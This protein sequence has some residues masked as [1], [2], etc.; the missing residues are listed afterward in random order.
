M[1]HKIQFTS[2]YD[3]FNAY[4]NHTFLELD[5]YEKSYLRMA[6]IFQINEMNCQK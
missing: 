4:L 6:A 1:Q 3:G 2:N 5:V